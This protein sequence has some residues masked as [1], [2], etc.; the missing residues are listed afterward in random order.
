MSDASGE[1]PTPASPPSPARVPRDDDALAVHERL[2]SELRRI[3]RATQISDKQLARDA[4]LTTSQLVLLG[5]LDANTSMTAGE[6]AVAMNL[7]QATVTSLVD[8]LQARGLVQRERAQAD[9]R[10]VR[11]SLTG[12]GRAHLA[13]APVSLQQRLVE[14]FGALER[15]EQTMIVSALQRITALM[16]AAAVD[17]APLLE[18]GAIGQPPAPASGAAEGSSRSA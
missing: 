4:G 8:R 18:A 12:P 17:A 10:V 2:L 15:W 16:D 3:I 7:T 14:R 5:L 9:R 1:P 13:H 6:I 11:V